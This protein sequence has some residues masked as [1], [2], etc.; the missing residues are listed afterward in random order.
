M[1]HKGFILL[2]LMNF[3]PWDFFDANFLFPLLSDLLKMTLY[4]FHTF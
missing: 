1:A 4:W 3:I 2:R